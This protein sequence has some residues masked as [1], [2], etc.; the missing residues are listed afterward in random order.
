MPKPR[1]RVRGC[2]IQIPQPMAM[3]RGY[4][5]SQPKPDV[6]ENIK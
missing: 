2:K 3:D 6:I 1:V 4:R 5:K